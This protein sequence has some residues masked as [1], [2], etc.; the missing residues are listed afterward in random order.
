ML[1]ETKSL[2]PSGLDVEIVAADLTL[3]ADRLRV[4][5]RAVDAF[6]GLDLLVNNAGIMDAA[7]FA[8]TSDGVMERML[9]TN[10][11][12]PFA[13]TRDLL[14]LLQAGNAPRIVN[15]GSLLGD[16]AMPNFAGYGATKFAL[17][18]LS[19]ALRRELK[20]LGIGLTHVAPRATKTEGFD[21]IAHLVD[22]KGTKLDDPRLLARRIVGAIERER[23]SLYPAGAELLFLFVQRFA[24][25]L[26]D[27]A[28]SSRPKETQGP[29]PI[30]QASA[31]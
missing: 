25:A 26:I 27:R 16:I 31:R 11:M 14:P 15:M 5:D 22:A 4:R 24:P 10:L 29:L 17:R 20:P 8:E 6:S 3:G 18:G 13:L 28:V 19:D 21:Q 23:R 1:E 2:F 30:P 9:A 7:P 12:A